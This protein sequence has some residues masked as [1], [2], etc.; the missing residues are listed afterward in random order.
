METEETKSDGLMAL[1]KE[2]ERELEKRNG[3]REKEIQLRTRSAWS[4]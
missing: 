2:Y 3:L 1:Q 4:R